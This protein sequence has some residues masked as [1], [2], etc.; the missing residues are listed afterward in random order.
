MPGQILLGDEDRAYPCRRAVERLRGYREEGLNLQ[1]RD[2]ETL[3]AK[4]ADC[5]AGGARR[6]SITDQQ[7]GSFRFEIRAHH[8]HIRGMRFNLA[9]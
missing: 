6:D 9:L 7:A 2:W 4:H 1:E 3:F 8:R 5:L